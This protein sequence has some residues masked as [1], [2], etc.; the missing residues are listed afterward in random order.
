MRCPRWSALTLTLLI[1]GVALG[2]GDQVALERNRQLL[3]RWRSNPDHIARL[4]RDLKVFHALPRARQEQLRTLDEQLHET[5]PATQA[6][7][8]AALERYNAWLAT[9]TD[10]Q[11][12][13]ITQ[14][15]D[16]ATRLARIRE[17]RLRE[18]LPRLTKSDQ[19]AVGRLPV[20]QQPG[21]IA[22]L[23]SEDRRQRG[24]SYRDWLAA[25]AA[26]PRP[27]SLKELPAET[28]AF[29]EANLMKRLT[30]VERE[31][32]RKAEGKYPEWFRLLDGLSEIHPVLPPTKKG[33]NINLKE[34][35]DN[36]AAKYRVDKFL[37]GKRGKDKSWPDW[38][39]DITRIAKELKTTIPTLGASK[40]SEFSPEIQKF[41]T[42]T[43]FPAL[44]REQR[45]QLDKQEGHWP[46]YPR[47]LLRLARDSQLV[48]PGMSLPGP[49]VMWENARAEAPVPLEGLLTEFARKELT[50]E[51][52]AQMGLK[53]GD[54]VGNREKLQSA[55]NRKKSEYE[56]KHKN[57]SSR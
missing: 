32:L 16:A 21:R 17:L 20:D 46:E 19:Q 57:G 1:F 56:R 48:I 6:R 35:P 47:M 24:A 41:L 3:A 26:I 45:T 29:V 9:R 37:K 38:A 39:L 4:K 33:E 36:V 52:F 28:R 27:T 14:A 42:Q 18:W 34:L 2:A 10:E 51:E 12:L 7:L 8:W 30:P 11:R 55:F 54:L 43:L 13:H 23:R 31:R 44:G 40:P 5:N 15:P 25:E 49:I 53:P 50:E 22:A